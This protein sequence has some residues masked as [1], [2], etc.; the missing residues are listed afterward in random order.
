[1][2]TRYRLICR[3][4][5]AGKFYS[6]DT[7]TGHRTSLRTSNEDEARQLVEAKNNSHR[8]PTLN[9]QLAR[10]YL[11][12]TDPAYMDRSWQNVMDEIQT[13]GRDSTQIRYIRGMKSRAFDSIA[14]RNCSKPP[15]RIFWPYSKANKCSLATEPDRKCASL[16]ITPQPENLISYSVF[17]RSHFAGP[18]G[19]FGPLARVGFVSGVETEP[20]AGRSAPMGPLTDVEYATAWSSS[21]VCFACACRLWTASS[22]NGVPEGRGK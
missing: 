22:G 8:Q 6:V 12:A 5:R 4:I 17:H 10:A 1:M 9:L 2:K 13:H 15:S 14:T 20:G 18:Q 3:G 7:R 19:R 21:T 11:T 16:S